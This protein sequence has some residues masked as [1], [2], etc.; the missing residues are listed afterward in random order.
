MVPNS[1]QNVVGNL[2]ERCCFLPFDALGCN[3]EN[4]VLQL[5]GDDAP[6]LFVG[7]EVENVLE[8]VGEVLYVEEEAIGGVFR[9]VEE[10]GLEGGF[11]VLRF[12]LHI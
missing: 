11:E 7:K 8:E 5:V 1:L 9:G 6:L 2:F 3:F 10:P 12:L 4:E